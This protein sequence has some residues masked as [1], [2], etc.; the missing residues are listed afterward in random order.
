MHIALGLTLQGAYY[1]CIR[2]PLE[3]GAT[4]LRSVGADC[5][6]Y[7]TYPLILH[8]LSYFTP[9]TLCNSWTWVFLFGESYVPGHFRHVFGRFGHI[10]PILNHIWSIFTRGNFHFSTCIE[11]SHV[12]CY[13]RLRKSLGII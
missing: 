7:P 2:R 12:T 8:L 13:Q 5:I 6:L 10:D 9:Q 1:V 11:S 3:R 4:M